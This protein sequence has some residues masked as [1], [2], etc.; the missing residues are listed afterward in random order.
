[1][2]VAG[3]VITLASFTSLAEFGHIDT[4]SALVFVPFLWKITEL[5]V[6]TL[7]PV[8]PTKSCDRQQQ[9]KIPAT[10]HLG[11][12]DRQSKAVNCG[13]LVIVSDADGSHSRI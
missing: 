1:M 6:R 7:M 13:H 10:A 8:K 11:D 5:R 2:A 3:I 9:I 4:Y 12:D